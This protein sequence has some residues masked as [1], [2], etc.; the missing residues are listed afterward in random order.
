MHIK[1]KLEYLKPASVIVIIVLFA[2]TL[3]NFL[4]CLYHTESYP[5]NS[6]LLKFSPALKQSVCILDVGTCRSG[7]RPCVGQLNEFVYFHPYCFVH[8][9]SRGIWSGFSPCRH[10]ESLFTPRAEE[11]VQA[12]LGPGICQYPFDYCFE[13]N[14]DCI[15]IEKNETGYI[16]IKE[17]LAHPQ[18]ATCGHY[19]VEKKCETSG[20][21]HTKLG[22][23]DGD[24]TQKSF[25]LLPGSVGAT[26]KTT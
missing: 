6:A 21:D 5:W 2:Y 11:V 24:G 9:Y 8:G 17:S 20:Y 18:C 3:L 15:K 26:N 4:Y 22:V 7:Q 16:G 10:L 25:T 12:D 13:N 19:L 1:E 23:V 14:R